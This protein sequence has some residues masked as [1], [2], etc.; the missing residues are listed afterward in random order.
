[1]NFYK[2][3]VRPILFKFSA[4]YAHELAIQSAGFVSQNRILT[5]LAEKIYSKN[6]SRLHQKI[7]G[8][9]FKNPVGLA[10]GFDKNGTTTYL[11]EAL[12]F[13]FLEVGSITANACTGN[14]KPRSFRLPEDQS[15]INRLG[16]NNDGAKTI[17]KRLKKHEH[18]VPIGVNIAKTHNPDISG[19]LALKDYHF[20]FTL[21]KKVADYITINISCP[22]TTEGKTFEDP[23]LLNKLL[24]HLEVGND[25]SDP[26]VLIK[27]SVDLDEHQLVELLDITESFAVS[28]YVATNTSARRDALK[29]SSGR[30]KR[31]GKGGL[32][33][34]AIRDKST[35]IIRQISEHT[36][37][38]KTI[39][40]VGG[41]T[42]AES[43]IEK[44]KAGADLLQIY[45]GMVFEGPSLVK[46]INSG[47]LRYLEEHNLDHVY[48]I[49]S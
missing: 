9:K 8:L 14:P 23:E 1:M 26:P 5:G 47:I 11:M 33:G 12:G 22:N 35:D 49:R 4:D 19:E 43:A 29:T 13:G 38:E 32:S 37:S 16:L 7:W 20:S 24:S 39:I 17:I 46:R 25:A 30:L 48:Q 28:G 27:F 45:T 2:V 31:I 41:V 21:A 44:I 10:A 18:D 40:G 36:K 15:L 34:R 6:D 3:A 42:D